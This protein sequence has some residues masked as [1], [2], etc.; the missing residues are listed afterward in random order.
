MLVYYAGSDLESRC[1]SQQNRMHSLQD[2]IQLLEVRCMDYKN[3][4]TAELNAVAK[5]HQQELDVIDARIRNLLRTKDE[6]I[7]QLQTQ[8]AESEG[9]SVEME[10]LLRELNVKH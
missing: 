6:T 2:E 8:L 3:K 1:Q 9:T 7:K 4:L 10:S 5:S